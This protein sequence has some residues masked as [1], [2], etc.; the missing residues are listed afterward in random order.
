MID[1]AVNLGK[2]K[3][4]LLDN[5]S[6]FWIKIFFPQPDIVMYIDCPEDIAFSRKDDIN[7][8]NVEYL[9]ERR[10]LYLKLADKYGWIKIEGTLPVDKIAIQVKEKVY[11]RMSR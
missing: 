11:E 1:Q 8:P 6:S 2:R 5:L 7:T 9:R 10:E 3:D 4:W